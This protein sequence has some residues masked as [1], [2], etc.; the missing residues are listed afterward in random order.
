[1]TENSS[2]FQI[3]FSS[4]KPVKEFF[5]IHSPLIKNEFSGTMILGVQRTLN[6]KG[7]LIWSKVTPPPVYVAME[8]EMVANT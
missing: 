1:M 8:V 2:T 4:S 6:K 3:L 7:L 5:A